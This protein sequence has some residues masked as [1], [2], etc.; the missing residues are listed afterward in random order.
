LSGIPFDGW[1]DR[2]YYL[3]EMAKM[4]KI[5]PKLDVIQLLNDQVTRLNDESYAPLG[6]RL[7]RAVWQWLRG[8]LSAQI[9]ALSLELT[10]DLAAV[11]EAYLKALA[12]GEKSV[13][14]HVANF[15]R[16]DGDEFY[17]RVSSDGDQA[18]IALGLDA[19]ETPGGDKERYRKL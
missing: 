4:H 14:L 1:V 16:A 17:K 5:N 10:D 15:E 19:P 13:V 12:A 2:D 9:V 8:E 7:E 18:V 11:C 6:V 3:E